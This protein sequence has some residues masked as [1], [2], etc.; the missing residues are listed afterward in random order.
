M[1]WYGGAPYPNNDNC[2]FLD[3]ENNDNVTQTD[4]IHNMLLGQV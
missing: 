3:I 2:I 4:Y 1:K